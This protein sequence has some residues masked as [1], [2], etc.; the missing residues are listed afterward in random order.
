MRFRR[1]E[2]QQEDA[3]R[4]VR[5]CH[6]DGS[7]SE[8]SLVRDPDD[9][10]GCAQWMAVPPESA[11]ADPYRDRLEVDFVPAHTAITIMMPVR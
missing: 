7:V 11:T 1:K 8:C 10:D 2:T 6:G 9:S 3:P 5:I 4:G